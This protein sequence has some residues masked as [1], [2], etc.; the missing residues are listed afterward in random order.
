MQFNEQHCWAAYPKRMTKELEEGRILAF[1]FE[2][3]SIAFH[4]CHNLQTQ[5][6]LFKVTERKYFFLLL[7]EVIY[8]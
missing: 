8:K 3:E 2:L 4:F 1:Y 5:K 7:I 6:K